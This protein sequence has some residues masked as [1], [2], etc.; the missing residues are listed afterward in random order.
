MFERYFSINVRNWRHLHI[1]KIK[2]LSVAFLLVFIICIIEMPITVIN[3]FVDFVNGTEVV[4]CL[5][6]KQFPFIPIW[7]QVCE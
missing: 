7:Q 2:T 3:G 6:S 5:E 4:H 1:N